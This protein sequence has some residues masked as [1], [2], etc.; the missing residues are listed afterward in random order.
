MKQT[1][2][3]NS[4]PYPE[5]LTKLSQDFLIQLLH[6]DGICREDLTAGRATGK[7]PVADLCFLTKLHV[8]GAEDGNWRDLQ[9]CF[10]D[11]CLTAYILIYVLIY[12]QGAEGERAGTI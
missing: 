12:W 10:S 1:A 5:T 7:Y 6:L 4:H 9:A 3:N 2:D 8:Q 11:N